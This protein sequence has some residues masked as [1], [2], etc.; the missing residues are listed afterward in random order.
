MPAMQST[1]RGAQ[2]K[3]FGDFVD[4]F[5]L[6]R[7]ATG[8]G[9][10][11]LGMALLGLPGCRKAEVIHFVLPSGFH[12]RIA[13]RPD[14]AG[15]SLARDASSRIIV[16]VPVNG[17]VRTR[18]VEMLRVWRSL[19]ASFQDGTQREVNDADASTGNGDVSIAGICGDHTGAIFFYVGSEAEIAQ[20]RK[21]SSQLVVAPD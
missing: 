12:G 1:I 8:A 16:P 19:C 2:L 7:H 11:C 5:R 13:V 21:N 6:R 20:I 4:T 3:C 18:D 17:V 10:F 14:V 15:I 9:Y